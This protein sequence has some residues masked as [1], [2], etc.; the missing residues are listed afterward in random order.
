[1]RILGAAWPASTANWSLP[2]LVAHLSQ[3][4]SCKVRNKDT[5]HQ[6][7]ASTCMCTHKHLYL[8]HTHMH[9]THIYYTHIQICACAQHRHMHT[10]RK[11]T[12]MPLPYEGQ[13]S[14]TWVLGDKPCPEGS[15]D[16]MCSDPCS[17]IIH[18]HPHCIPPSVDVC[19]LE[20]L[21]NTMANW[22]FWGVRTTQRS[23]L[24]VRSKPDC[25][26]GHPYLQQPLS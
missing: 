15:G 8:T 10:Q 26:S 7:V 21:T 4:A 24:C 19:S 13:S 25:S 12:A 9:T 18:L 14:N 23:L 20:L 1:M 2:V 17:R 16:E 11:H 3:K 22:I 5:W 6:P